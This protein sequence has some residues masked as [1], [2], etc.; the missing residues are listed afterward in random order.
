MRQSNDIALRFILIVK[1]RMAKIISTNWL[2]YLNQ[3]L[4]QLHKVFCLPKTP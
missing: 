2:N 4:M 1:M 3:N